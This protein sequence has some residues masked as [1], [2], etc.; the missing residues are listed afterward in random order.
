M[1]RL[2]FVFLIT[3]ILIAD[4][5]RIDEYPNIPYWPEYIRSGDADQLNEYMR[6]LVKDLAKKYR[7]T[8]LRINLGIDLNDTDIRYFGTM[9]ANGDYADGDWRIIKVGSD[10]FEIQKLISGTWTQQAKW[11]VASGYETDTIAATSITASAA[12][13]V[14]GIMTSDT[15]AAPDIAAVTV[16]CGSATSTTRGD[17]NL[18]AGSGGSAP[19]VICMYSADGTAWFLFVEDDG[20]VKIHNALPTQNSDGS[21]VGGQS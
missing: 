12:V 7:E 14:S 5:N 3:G 17:I 20:T 16:T 8:A 6:I 13:T 11:S 2:L 4:I 1:K 10:D 19:G 21:A 18:F 9:D 15:V